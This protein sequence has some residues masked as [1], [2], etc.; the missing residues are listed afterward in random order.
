MT[1]EQSPCPE[2]LLA[3]HLVGRRI[4]AVDA[5]VLHLDDGTT[6]TLYESAQDCCASAQGTWEI[7][8]ASR[9]EAA[10]TDV[11]FEQHRRDVGDWREA[12]CKIT[13]LH[14]QNPVA[15]GEGAANAGNA[16][17]YYS[18]LSLKITANGHI[19]HDEEILH[20]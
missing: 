5:G 20:S 1:N 10:I 6:C 19:V 13:I 8:D 9:L 12:T 2:Q 14:N 3:E 17:Y 18:V 7:L 16:G 4:T 15:L 11:E